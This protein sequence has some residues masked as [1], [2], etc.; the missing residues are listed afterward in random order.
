MKKRIKWSMF[1]MAISI[2]V[3]VCIGLLF[4]A[5]PVKGGKPF[6]EKWLFFSEAMFVMFGGGGFVAA[7]LLLVTSLPDDLVFGFGNGLYYGAALGGAAIYELA[8]GAAS[9]SI[10]YTFSFVVT[11]LICYIVWLKKFKWR[12]EEK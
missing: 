6:L 10:C 7:L 9:E 8:D 5:I 4:C 1:Y 2:G 12:Y 11:A 3:S